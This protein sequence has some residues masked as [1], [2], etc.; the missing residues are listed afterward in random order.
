MRVGC[1]L[2]VQD[3]GSDKEDK[4]RECVPG[5]GTAREETSAC[6]WCEPRLKH[7]HYRS[8]A[9]QT[10]KNLTEISTSDPPDR[11]RKPLCQEV[12]CG[13]PALRLYME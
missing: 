3:H 4:A 5:R 11:N 7:F 8:M 13:K 12:T 10:L 2:D 1:E 6:S 9:S